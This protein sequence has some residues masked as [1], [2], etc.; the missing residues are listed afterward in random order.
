MYLIILRERREMCNY[1]NQTQQHLTPSST[2]V[3]F[4][5]VLGTTL[6]RSFL[7]LLVVG[8]FVLFFFL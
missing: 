5:K 7:L 3:T 8:F 1:G 4:R 2:K 6:P